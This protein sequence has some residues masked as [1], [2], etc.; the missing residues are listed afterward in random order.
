M[1][2]ELESANLQL[3]D[4]EIAIYLLLRHWSPKSYLMVRF[5]G[6][7][8]GGRCM[9]GLVIEQFLPRG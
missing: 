5:A 1:P 6:V 2:I 3:T 8:V 7:M 4:G 9:V